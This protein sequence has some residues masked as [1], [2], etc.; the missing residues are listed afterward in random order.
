MLTYCWSILILFFHHSLNSKA[1]RLT[2]GII[3]FFLI[4]CLSFKFWFHLFCFR[5]IEC[6]IFFLD[7]GQFSWIQLRISPK[8]SWMMIPS[9]YVSWFIFYTLNSDLGWK[10]ILHL[11]VSKKLFAFFRESSLKIWT[12]NS[13]KTIS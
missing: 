5:F 13:C 3:C 6:L 10:N 1:S 8:N 7:Y 12:G 9:D 2:K 4:V 11:F